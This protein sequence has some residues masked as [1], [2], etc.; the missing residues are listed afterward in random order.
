MNHHHWVYEKKYYTC[1]RFEAAVNGTLTSTRD[2][3]S[4]ENI[5]A[6]IQFKTFVDFENAFERGAHAMVIDI[7]H[8]SVTHGRASTKYFQSATLEVQKSLFTTPVVKHATVVVQDHHQFNTHVVNALQ[9]A[10]MVFVR[11]GL[12]T[13]LMSCWHLRM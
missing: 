3:S 4:V 13:D 11:N 6:C 5:L 9:P 8:L 10:R 1:L 12:V 7:M 2:V